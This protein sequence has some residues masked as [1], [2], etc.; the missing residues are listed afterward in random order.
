KTTREVALLV[1]TEITEPGDNDV[2]A[3][4]AV[5]LFAIYEKQF[6]EISLRADIQ[7][8]DEVFADHSAGIGDLRHQQQAR[9]FERP[10]SHYDRA[11]RFDLTILSR[12]FVDEADARGQPL[13]VDI[14]LVRHRIGNQRESSGILLH[15]RD[16][17]TERRV[18][19]R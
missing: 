19:E 3:P 13:R 2:R 6:R 17:L 16:D 12:R 8:L 5:A 7:M 14:D 11:A 1:R 4:D 9:A 15:Q 10:A 18:V